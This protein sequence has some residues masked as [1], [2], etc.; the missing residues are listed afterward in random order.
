M[1][2]KGHIELTGKDV[3]ALLVFIEPQI[4]SGDRIMSA[5]KLQ[6]ETTTTHKE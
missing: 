6:T 5:L 4:Q 3:F 2:I 1:K